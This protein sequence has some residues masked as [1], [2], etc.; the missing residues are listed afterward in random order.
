MME[1]FSTWNWILER[2]IALAGF[3][4]L[5]KAE[6]IPNAKEYVCAKGE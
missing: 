3:D 6:D 2:L 1:E 4:I 5:T